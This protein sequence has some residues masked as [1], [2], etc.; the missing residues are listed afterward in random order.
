[1]KSTSALLDAVHAGPRPLPG[2]AL[3]METPCFL[4]TVLPRQD[5]HWAGSMG[6]ARAGVVPRVLCRSA[7]ELMLVL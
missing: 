1:M 6:A 7:A 3:R 2:W 4:K 5:K